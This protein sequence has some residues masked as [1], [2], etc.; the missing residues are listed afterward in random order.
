MGYPK[1][2]AGL[3]ELL[4]LAR[5]LILA[6]EFL[7]SFVGSESMLLN[8]HEDVAKAWRGMSGLCAT[9]SKQSCTCGPSFFFLHPSSR[10][11]NSLP[12]DLA[13]YLRGTNC[14]FLLIIPAL[15]C[16]IG[17]YVIENSPR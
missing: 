16:L 14:E 12:P 13:P 17:L 3:R 6:A 7:S 9:R 2:Y 10:H 15:P 11:A 1:I 5:F 4:K 8:V